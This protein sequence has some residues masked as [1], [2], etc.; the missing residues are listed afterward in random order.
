MLKPWFNNEIK[1]QL[2]Q[3]D[4]A[5]FKFKHFRVQNKKARSCITKMSKV[6]KVVVGAG[7][8]DR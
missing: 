5:Y 3:R 1:N 6:A 2:H 4:V 7:W 8:L